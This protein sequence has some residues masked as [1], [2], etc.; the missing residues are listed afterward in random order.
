MVQESAAAAEL[1]EAQRQQ[2]Q[3]LEALEE[4]RKNMDSAYIE[5]SNYQALH[6]AAW[7]D[8]KETGRTHSELKRKA[9]EAHTKPSVQR[10]RTR[11]AT[12]DHV[13]SE[14]VLNN[15]VRCLSNFVKVTVGVTHALT[16]GA[17]DLYW[18]RT[19]QLTPSPWRSSTG[20]LTI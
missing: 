19:R 16:C 14:E 6:E 5:F 4:C 20:D 12:S 1:G 8:V 2:D 10:D 9:E 15:N 3:A 7:F 11:C 13:K 18:R 17:P